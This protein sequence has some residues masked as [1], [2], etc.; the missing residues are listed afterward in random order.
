MKK[1]FPLLLSILTVLISACSNEYS[2]EYIN[3]SCPTNQDRILKPGG[4]D[5]VIDVESTHSFVFTSDPSEACD[6]INDGVVT[7]DKEGVALVKKSYLVGVK[8]NP[9]NL[10]REI[11]IY[12]KQKHN[13]NIL[14]SIIFYQPAP[15]EA[16]YVNSN[17]ANLKPEGEEITIRIASTQSYVLT[18]APAGA[19]TFE[20]NGVVEY[21]EEESGAS[22]V[23]KTHKVKIEPNTTGEEREITIVAT[24]NGSPEMFASLVFTQPG[25]AN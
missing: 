19:C 21:T 3:A 7:Y 18:A 15:I 1:Y 16:D 4:D 11:R 20:N 13:P 8:A 12:A 14:T 5:L 23:S 10:G 9:T 24:Q 22:L 17:N 2:W 25:Q 6:F